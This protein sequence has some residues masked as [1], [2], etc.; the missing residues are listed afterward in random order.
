M[1]DY[2]KAKIY[3]ATGNGLN[4]YGSTIN[5]LSQ[6]LSGH[7]NDKKNGKTCSMFSLLEME[8]F[9]FELV[10]NYPCNNKKELLER[11]RFYIEN[12]DC[13]NKK[14]PIITIK[15]EKQRRKIY[16]QNHKDMNKISN[17]KWNDKNKEQQKEYHKKWYEENKEKILEQQRV[18]YYENKEKNKTY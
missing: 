11:E 4:Y 15:E 14:K 2:S 1:S 8:D 7:K 5:T 6:R 10:E 16:Q 13:V 17:K 3:K 12:N 9:K 18:R